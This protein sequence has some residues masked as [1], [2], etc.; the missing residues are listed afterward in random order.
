MATK[1]EVGK[2]YATASIGDHECIFKVTVTKRTEK[3]VTITGFRNKRCKVHTDEK[4]VEYIM[5]ETYS[6]APIFDATEVDE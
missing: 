5:P 6:F 4:G 3:T 2:T 1:F